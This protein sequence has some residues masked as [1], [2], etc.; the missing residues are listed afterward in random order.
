M[1][2]SNDLFDLFLVNDVAE[3]LELIYIYCKSVIWIMSE[4]LL[5]KTTSDQWELSGDMMSFL[6]LAFRTNSVQISMLF[7]LS[8]PSTRPLAVQAEG[9]LWLRV[10]LRSRPWSA[11]HCGMEVWLP[12]LPTRICSGSGWWEAVL[13]LSSAGEWSSSGSLLHPSPT[14]AKHI[15]SFNHNIYMLYLWIELCGTQ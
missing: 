14:A 2:T 15:N 9:V 1:Y 3:T 13:P 10:S 5:K 12:L 11:Q 4:L 6:L 7:N 8:L